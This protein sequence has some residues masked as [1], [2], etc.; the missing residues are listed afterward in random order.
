MSKQ[1][2]ILVLDL[3][4]FLGAGR[5][6]EYTRVCAPVSTLPQLSQILNDNQML[7]LGRHE[8]TSQEF[9]EKKIPA[10]K[11][12]FKFTKVEQTRY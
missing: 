5:S 1:G 2:E 12:S 8:V 11:M 7:C 3:F 10:F 4:P 6:A 9:R